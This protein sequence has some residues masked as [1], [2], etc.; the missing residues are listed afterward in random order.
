LFKGPLACHIRRRSNESDRKQNRHY[1]KQLLGHSAEVGVLA[2]SD[3]TLQ[4]QF[5]AFGSHGR[6]IEVRR[7]P[8]RRRPSD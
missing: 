1:K 6:Q 5:C 7:N 2:S 3:V 4:R 8:E